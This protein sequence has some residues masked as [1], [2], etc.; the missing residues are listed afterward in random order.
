MG[1]TCESLINA[2]KSN[3]PKMLIGL[4][5]KGTWPGSGIPT[6]PDADVAPPVERRTL[7]RSGTNGERGKPVVSPRDFGE[8]Q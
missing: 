1:N 8:E 4:N 3:K 2:V 5:Q 7:T 6:S